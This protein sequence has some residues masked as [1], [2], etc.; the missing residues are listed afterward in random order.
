MSQCNALAKCLRY[1]CLEEKQ[2]TF[3]W[4]R[5]V[6]ISF[7]SPQCGSGRERTGALQRLDPPP[8]NTTQ[9]STTQHNTWLF[10]T[11]SYISKH[12]RGKIDQGANSRTDLVEKRE[13]WWYLLH[14]GKGGDLG[15]AKRVK[16]FF[17]FLSKVGGVLWFW[18]KVGAATSASLCCNPRL[19]ESERLSSSTSG[20][21]PSVPCYRHCFVPYD[22]R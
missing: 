14:K 11:A 6:I 3:R 22:I 17:P 16:C 5:N 21:S 10:P 8:S 18:C 7:L 20:P 15:S 4:R 2:M 19:E 1:F 9:H 12:Q 13:N